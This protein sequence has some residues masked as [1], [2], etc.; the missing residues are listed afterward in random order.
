MKKIIV[1]LAIVSIA[2]ISTVA[3]AS[4]LFA[5]MSA[6]TSFSVGSDLTVYG[7]Q[8]A[9]DTAPSSTF[10]AY[11]PCTQGAFPAWS[12]PYPVNHSLYGGDTLTYTFATMTDEAGITPFLNASTGAYGYIALSSDYQTLSGPPS[13]SP[14]LTGSMS[15]GLP[16]MAQGQW[17]QVWAVITLAPNAPAATVVTLVLNFTK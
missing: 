8:V 14:T 15:S 9:Y 6:S 13:S 7:L 12:C 16:L 17:Y 11:Q 2:S 3:F 1:I 10:T 5:T 4:G